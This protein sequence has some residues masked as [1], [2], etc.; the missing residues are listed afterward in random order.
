MIVAPPISNLRRN[1]SFGSRLSV[2]EAPLAVDGGRSL[3]PSSAGSWRAETSRGGP[4]RAAMHP[5]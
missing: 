4:R 5:A 3:V 1:G 2:M